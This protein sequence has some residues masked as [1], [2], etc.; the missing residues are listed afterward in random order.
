[1]TFLNV[2]FG[3]CCPL[4]RWGT[5]INSMASSLQYFVQHHF[6][7]LNLKNKE[8][9]SP[10]WKK[11]FSYL[12]QSPNFD[13]EV[14]NSYPPNQA[15]WPTHVVGDKFLSCKF[16][17]SIVGRESGMLS[18]QGLFYSILFVSQEVSWESILILERQEAYHHVTSTPSYGGST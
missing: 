17:F 14:R 18:L 9:I 15:L 7:H 6:I 5:I 13:V 8:I 10:L 1:M 16:C 3:K 4:L 11:L 12:R 2:F